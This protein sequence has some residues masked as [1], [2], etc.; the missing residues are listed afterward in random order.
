M[1]KVQKMDK[2]IIIA[3]AANGVQR[4]WTR[5]TFEIAKVIA[6]KAVKQLKF[7]SAEIRDKFNYSVL[8]VTKKETNDY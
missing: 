6:N 4:I 2:F 3:T 5:S 8:Y 1:D 7:E